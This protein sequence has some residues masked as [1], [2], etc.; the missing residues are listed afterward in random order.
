MRQFKEDK[1]CV[2]HNRLFPGYKRLISV[3]ENIKWA[4]FKANM[5]YFQTI[6]SRFFFS[7]IAVWSRGEQVLSSAGLLLDDEALL[8]IFPLFRAGDGEDVIEDARIWDP[9]FRVSTAL[10]SCGIWSNGSV[11]PEPG[12]VIEGAI[13]TSLIA[14][15][16]DI[17]PWI[18]ILEGSSRIRPSR[19]VRL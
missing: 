7:D 14:V 10:S 4:E 5:F 12:H 1:I 6:L 16:D 13:I 15:W 3:Y 19:D 2:S 18:P 17:F 8:A 9:R 11:L